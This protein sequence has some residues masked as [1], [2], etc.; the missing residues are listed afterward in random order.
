M[1]T[2]IYPKINVDRYL[3]LKYCF[4]VLQLYEKSF[5]PSLFGISA[6]WFMF[7]I[8]CLCFMWEVA[9]FPNDTQGESFLL[10]NSSCEPPTTT[11][12]LTV[13][14][15]GMII[16]VGMNF[17]HIQNMVKETQS[18]PQE[19]IKICKLFGQFFISWP[20][21]SGMSMYTT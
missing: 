9:L 20:P 15:C 18:E 4:S 12:Q 6:I 8:F 11:H 2:K 10:G 16:L 13:C 1:Q 7:H 17:R 3:K 21:S 19:V 5:S 14:L